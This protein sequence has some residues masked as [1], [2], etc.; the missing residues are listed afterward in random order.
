MKLLALLLAIV[1]SGVMA[2]NCAPRPD[3]VDMLTNRY[4]E[5]PLSRGLAQPG[6]VETWGNRETGTFTIT[7][8]LPNGMTCMV[9]SGDAFEILDPVTGE[10]V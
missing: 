2:Q 8:T 1:P 7:V 5:V 6:I 9:A 4:G 3:V 10:P